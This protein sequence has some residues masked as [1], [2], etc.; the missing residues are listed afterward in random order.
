MKE[1]YYKHDVVFTEQFNKALGIMNR[2]VSGHYQPGAPENM[3]YMAGTERRYGTPPPGP[4][5]PPM[6][7][8][9]PPPLM[10]TAP[11]QVK[12]EYEVCYRRYFIC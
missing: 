10:A 1:M 3:A 5:P 6:S 9:P 8:P 7:A 12:R 4:P 2:A 11:M